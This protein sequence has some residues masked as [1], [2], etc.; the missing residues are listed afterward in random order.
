MNTLVRF[1]SGGK[2][3]DLEEMDWEKEIINYP[4]GTLGEVKINNVINGMVSWQ[5]CNLY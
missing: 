1:I 5:N 3:T 2:D 4:G